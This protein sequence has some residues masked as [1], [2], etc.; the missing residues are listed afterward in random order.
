MFGSPIPRRL[1]RTAVVSAGLALAVAVLSPSAAVANKGGTDRPIKD[2]ETGTSVLNLLTG[3]FVADTTGVESHLG[4]VASH[5][6]GV[7]T[8]TGPTTFTVTGSEIK[9]AANGDELFETFSG[10]GTLDAAGVAT[11]PVVVTYTGGT[12][13]FADRQRIGNRSVQPSAY[14]DSW[15][16]GDVRHQRLVER[17]DQLLNPGWL[18]SGSER[19]VAVEIPVAEPDLALPLPPR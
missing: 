7:V 3:A 18:R 6:E 15:D 14:L 10:S 4:R 8:T 19:P 16:D 17:H 11:G 5:Q 13:R 12:G 9:V 1:L 2:D